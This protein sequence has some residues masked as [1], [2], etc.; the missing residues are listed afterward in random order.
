MFVIIVH[1]NAQ[2]ET[3]LLFFI[4]YCVPE[5]N[6]RKLYIQACTVGDCIW[7]CVLYYAIMASITV[8]TFYTKWK[9]H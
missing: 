8:D 6:R 9:T 3:L 2:P 1:L 7:L 5:H 4:F